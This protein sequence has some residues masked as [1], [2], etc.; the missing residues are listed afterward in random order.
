MWWNFVG[1][2]HDEIAQAR[3][4]WTSGSRFGDVRGY[5]GAPLAAPTLPPRLEPRGRER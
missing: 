1:R 2:T 5:D 3:E 4:D